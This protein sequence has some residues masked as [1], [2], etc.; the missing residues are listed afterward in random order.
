MT[1]KPT[2]NVAVPPGLGTSP[3]AA[4]DDDDLDVLGFKTRD[5]NDEPDLLDLVR[6][7]LGIGV[8][9]SDVTIASSLAAIATKGDQRSRWLAAFGSPLGKVLAARGADLNAA[10]TSL[11]ALAQTR[12]S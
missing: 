5:A 8:D 1:S 7:R 12:L 11:V 9:V 2:I 6:E 4:D 10:L 3:G